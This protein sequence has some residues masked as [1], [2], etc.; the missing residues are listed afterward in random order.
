V[1]PDVIDI[2]GCCRPAVE[3]Q[4]WTFCEQPWLVACVL[5]TDCDLY[6]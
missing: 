1:F 3:L 4:C 6:H 5:W 2:S